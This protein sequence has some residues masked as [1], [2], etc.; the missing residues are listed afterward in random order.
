MHSSVETEPISLTLDHDAEVPM[1]AI[2]GSTF[3]PRVSVVV[4]VKNGAAT[5]A[6]CIEALLGQDYPRAL[7]EIL[8]VD[9]GSTDDTRLA[10]SRYPVTLLGGADVLTSYAARNCG[11]AHA[12]GDVIALTDADCTPE[13]D[14]LRRLVAPLE[15]PT[16]GAVAGTVADAPPASLCEEF[17]ARVTPF[18][19]PERGG[20]QT[21]LTG[22]VAIR[23]ATLEALGRF[24]ERLPTAGDVDLGW[25]MQR[26]LGLGV[27][28][29]A[30]ARVVHRHRS[31]FRGVFAQYRRYGSSEVLLTTLYGG[32]AGSLTAGQQVR[33][34]ADQ[35][36]A[37]A[38]YVIGFLWRS[39]VSLFRGFDRRYVLW[40][41]F[42]LTVE[43]GN[44]LGKVGAL[45]A[46]RFYRRNPYSNPRVERLG[47]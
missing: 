36:R 11:I 19:R 18:A 6:Q 24:D 21:L 45:F 13:P 28:E 23:R 4:P 37:M 30:D 25:R 5:I 38:S 1:P 39:G 46:T 41:L 8:V 3:Q 20:L 16:V 42:L 10:V 35:M 9:S 43:S 22:N 15:D 17:T 12:S 34:M 31:T 27:H 29:A 33:R 40:P 44:F 47:R 7:T 14:W 32:G 26:R 2:A